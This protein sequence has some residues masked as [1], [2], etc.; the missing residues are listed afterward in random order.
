MSKNNTKEFLLKIKSHLEGDEAKKEA[1]VLQKDLTKI[2]SDVKASSGDT[3]QFKELE[4]FIRMLESHMDALVAEHGNDFKEIFSGLDAG[5]VKQMQELFQVTK[6]EL[7]AVDQ[8]RKKIANVQTSGATQDEANAI[9]AE[10]EALYATLGR[11]GEINI[12]DDLSPKQMVGESLRYLNNFIVVWDDVVEK[13]SRGFGFGG[14][15]LSKEIQEEVDK[16]TATK[17]QLQRTLDEVSGKKKTKVELPKGDE[18]QLDFL[19]KLVANYKEA[20][21]ARKSF[22]TRNDT[23][24]DGYKQAVAE[25]IAAAKR[26]KS[27]FDDDFNLGDDAMKYTVKHLEEYDDAEQAIAKFNKDKDVMLSQIESLYTQKM[28]GIEADIKNLM[29]GNASQQTKENEK[30]AISYDHLDQAIQKYAVL[31]QQVNDGMETNEYGE[32]IEGLIR[33]FDELFMSLSKTKEESKEVS[34]ILGDLSFGDIDT[35]QALEQLKPLLNIGE[36]SNFNTATAGFKTIAGEAERTKDA[37]GGLDDATTDTLKQDLEQI[38]KLAFQTNKELSF[39]VTADG[40]K[41]V[42]ESMEGMVKVSEEAAAAVHSVNSNMSILAHSHPGGKGLFSVADLYGG[43]NLKSSGA[44]SPIMALSK[45]VASVLN[46]DG[47]TDDVINKVRAKLDSLPKGQVMNQQI[48]TEIQDIFKD[49]GFEGA[50]QQ[51]NIKNGPD[52]LVSYLQ[53]ITVHAQE[54]QTPLEKLQGLISYYSNG[55]INAGN[56]SQFS[57][58]WAEFERGANTA[59]E[60]FDAVMAKIDARDKEGNLM[61]VGTADYQPLA[62]AM[63]NIA[64]GDNQ[65]AQG[66]FKSAQDA[67]NDF[68][69]IVEHVN[70]G[71]IADEFELGAVEQRLNDAKGALD[72]LHDQGLITFEQLEDATEDYERALSHL[73]EI[74]DEFIAANDKSWQQRE[75]LEIHNDLLKLQNQANSTDDVERLNQIIEKRNK[76]LEEAEKTNY[77]AG[78]ELDAERAITAEIEKRIDALRQTGDAVEE[79]NTALQQQKELYKYIEDA[80]KNNRKVSETALGK[81]DAEDFLGKTLD[82][83]KEKQKALK[84]YLKELIQI[85][86]QEKRNG[87][88]TEDEVNRR[89]ELIDLINDVRLGVRYKDG[90]NYDSGYFSEYSSSLYEDAEK[91]NEIVNLRKGIALGYYGTGTFGTMADTYNGNNIRDLLLE[92]AYKFDGDIQEFDKDMIGQ[93]VREYQ[94]LHQEM[95]ECLRV[96]DEVPQSTLDRLRWF[97]SLDTSKIEEVLPRLTEL[98]GKIDA[99]ESSG[100]ISLGHQIKQDDA[101]YDEKISNFQELI[102]LKKE[103]ANLGGPR[104]DDDYYTVDDLEHQLDRLVDAKNKSNDWR[105]LKT[106]FGNEHPDIDLENDQ[107][108]VDILDRFYNGWFKYDEALQK[109]NATYD[110]HNAAIEKA[111]AKL[112]EFDTV[113]NKVQNEKD[114]MELSEDELTNYR[115]ELE[116]LESELQQLSSQGVITAQDLERVGTSYKDI[117]KNI[118]NALEGKLRRQRSDEVPA[119]NVPDGDQVPDSNKSK[120]ADEINDLETLRLK[121]VEVQGAINAKTQAFVDEA[122]VVGTVVSKE[123]EALEVLGKYVDT[124]GANINSIIEGLSKIDNAKLNDSDVKTDSSTPSGSDSSYALDSTVKRTNEILGGIK[125]ALSGENDMSKLAESLK[126]AVDE[127]K[128][129]ASGIVDEQNRQKN[130]DKAIS[131]IDSPEKRAQLSDIVIQ[132]VS[133]DNLDNVRI[134]NNFRQNEDGTVDIGYALKNAE[135]VW[136]GYIAKVN[137]SNEV[138]KMSVN[139]HSLYAKELNEV[140][141]AS[142]KAADATE[143]ESNAKKSVKGPD[144]T[145]AQKKKYDVLTHAADPYVSD[146]SKVYSSKVDTAL[147]NYKNAFK[148]LKNAKEAVANADD[149]DIEDE[150]RKFNIASDACNRYAKELEDLIKQSS[151]FDSTHSNIIPVKRDTYNLDDLEESKQALIDYVNTTYEGKA[152][153]KEF[154]ES[155]K[156]LHF[157]M[158]DADGSIR[159]MH[160]A[161]D[162]T[163][164]AIGTAVGKIR[165]EGSLLSN[166]FNGLGKEATKLFRYFAARFGIE[167]VFQAFRTG[168]QYVRDI[169]RALTELKKVTSETDATYQNFLQTMSQVGSVI[170]ATTA[171]LVN[172]SADWARLGYSIQE[173]GELAKNTAILLNVSEFENVEEAT[174]AMVASLQAYGDQFDP[175]N[176]IEMIDKLNIVGNNF[177]VSSDGIAEALKRSASTLVESGNDFEQSIAMVAAAN[178]VIQDPEQVGAAL[179]VLSMRIRGTKTELEAMGESTDDMASTTSKLRDQVKALT[180]IDGSG[181]VDILTESGEYRDTYDILLDIA[182]VYDDILATDN[183]DAAALTELLAGKHRANVLSSLLQNADDLKEA[184]EMAQNAEGSAMAENERYLDSIQGR[185]DLFTNSLQT[186][187]MNFIDSEVIKGVVDAGTIL[188]KILDTLPGKIAAI[189]SGIMIY[190][191]ATDGIKF[192]E[193]FTGFINISGQVL[194]GIKSVATATTSLTGIT[195][196]QAIARTISDR[197]TKKQIISDAGLTAVNGKLTASQIKSTAA[198]LGEAR[199]NGVLTTSQYLAMMSTMGLKTALQGLWTVLKANPIYIVA[200]AATGL[201]LAFDAVFDTAQES[202]DEAQNAF[203]EVK[204]AVESTESTIQSLESE[205]TEIQNK[206]N[207]INGN[208]LSFAEDQELERLKAQKQELEHSLEVQKSILELQKKSQSEKAVDAMHAYTKAASQGAEETQ[209]S[210][211]NVLTTIGAIIGAGAA[212]A[213]AVPTGG[214]SL[215]AGGT[216]IGSSIAAAGLGG[217]TTGAIAGGIAGNKA[218]EWFGS[219]A[220][221]ND[222]G[223]DA[224]Y[225]TYTKALETA[226]AEKEKALKNYENDPS[227]I[228]KL[229]KWQEAE[230]KVTDIETEMYD[231]ISQLQQYYNS[232]DYDS[233]SNDVKAELNSWDQFLDKFNIDQGGA[234]AKATALDRIFGEN[235]SKEIKEIKAEIKEAVVTGKD[236]D[237]SA[238]INGSEDLRTALEY[239]GLEVQDVEDYFTQL[240]ESAFVD[241]NVTSFKGYSALVAQVES[242]NSALAQTSDYIFDNV[243]VTQEYKDS[244]TALGI[245]QDEL[246]DCF[247]ENNDLI[248]KNADALNELVDAARDNVSANIDVAE[249]HARLKYYDLVNQLNEVCSSTDEFTQSSSNLA[250]SLLDQIDAVQQ[251]IYKYHLLQN[252]LEGADGAFANF[253]EAKNIDSLNTTGATMIEMMQTLYDGFYKTGEVGTQA[254]EAAIDGLIPDSVLAGLESKGDQLEAAFKY[255][256]EELLPTLTKENDTISIGAGDVNSFIQEAINADVLARD[257]N[258]D[259]D[260]SKKALKKEWDFEDIGK[261]MGYSEAYVNAMMH[262]VDKNL[263]DDNISVK[264]SQGFEKFDNQILEITENIEDANRQKLDLLDQRRLTEDKD[265]IAAIDK[266]IGELNTTIQDNQK[267]MGNL[268]ETA[269]AE[270]E[271][272][273]KNEKAIAGLTELQDG[274]S[275]AEKLTATLTKDQ[276]KELGLKWKEGKTVQQYLDECLGKKDKLGEPTELTIQYALQGLAD[277]TDDLMNQIKKQLGEEEF[278]VK[279]KPYVEKNDDGTYSIDTT[280]ESSS[281]TRDE[282][283]NIVVKEGNY[284]EEELSTLQQIAENVNYTEDLQGISSSAVTAE[285]HLADISTNV[286][287]I[288]GKLGGNPVQSDTNKDGKVDTEKD[289]T[290]SQTN[291]DESGKSANNS[292]TDSKPMKMEDKPLIDV[293]KKSTEAQQKLAQAEEELAQINK[294]ALDP[295]PKSDDEPK[296]NY[297]KERTEKEQ[298]IRNL[299][300]QVDTEAIEKIENITEEDKEIAINAVTKYEQGGT[301][302]DLITDLQSIDPE[303]KTKVVATLVKEG[304]FDEL[305]SNLDESE[306]QIVIQAVTQGIGDAERLNEV[307]AGIENEEVRAEVGVLIGEALKNVDY[308]EGKLEATDG[309][310]INTTINGDSTGA[311]EAATIAEEKITGVTPTWTTA[312]LGDS[313]SAVVAAGTAQ[314]AI[315]GVDDTKETKIKATI[316]DSFWEKIRKAKEALAGVV[317]VNGTVHANGT[318]HAKGTAWAGGTA[319]KGGS[320]GAK[321]TETALVGELG[322]EIV[323]RGSR[324]FTVGDQGAEFANIQKGD[325]IFNHKQTEELFANGYITSRGKMKGTAHAQG[326]AYAGATWSI[327]TK[328]TNGKYKVKKTTKS[329]NNKKKNNKK[330]KEEF[331]EVFDWF[332]VRIEEINEDLDL[333]AAKLENAASLKSK[334]T[335]LDSMIKTNK[336]ELTTLEKGYQLYNSYANSILKK[337]K[338]VKNKKTGKYESQY[339]I[340]KKYWDEV[341][342][343]KIA[344]EEFYG[345]VDEKTL[346][347]IKNYREWAQKVADLKQQLQEVKTTIR[348]LAKQKIDNIADNWDNKIAVYDTHVQE[349]NQNYIDYTEESGKIAST[350]NYERMRTE[351]KHKKSHLTSK[352]DKMQE[353]FNKQVKNGNIQRGTDEWWEAV[354]AIQAINSEIDECNINLEKYQNAINQI[355][356]DTFDEVIKRFGYFEDEISSL[357]DMMSDAEMFKTTNENMEFWGEKDV[358]YTD[359]A[360]ASMGLYVEQMEIAK[361]KQQEYNEQIK[362]LKANKGNYSESEYKEKLAELTQGVYDSIEAQQEAKNALVDLEKA[363]VEYVKKGIEKQIEAYEELINKKKEELDA[364]KDLYDFQKGVEDQR[365]NISDIERKIAALAGDNSSAAVAERKR[366]E[367]ELAEAKAELE[368]TYYER[369]IDQQQQALDNELETFT[370]SKEAEIEALEKSTEEVDRIVSEATAE[371]NAR[372]DKIVELLTTIATANGVAVTQTVKSGVASTSKNAGK[373]IDDDVDK[374][375]KVVNKAANTAATDIVKKSSAVI[376]A[377]PKTT[378]TTTKTNT[379]T[380]N[381]KKTSTTNGKKTTT[382]NGKKTNTNS[383]KYYKEYTGKSGSIVDALKAI[384]VNSSYDNRAKIAKAN[385]IKNYSGTAKQNTKMLSLL[386]DGKLKKYA[387]GSLG[388]YRDQLAL[389]DELGEE[390]QLV[391]GNNGRLE[392]VKKGTGI[393]PADLTSNLMEWGKLDPQAMLEQN[394][395]AVGASPEVHATEVNL[396]IQYGDMLRIENFKGDNP[397]EIAKIV[398]KQFEKHTKDLNNALRKYVR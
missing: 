55:K 92:G 120:T 196:K 310:T 344:I 198:T 58:Y 177:A 105:K 256:K 271:K 359:E 300:I 32:D 12:A 180:N 75:G 273:A 155:V 369:S 197:A 98:K 364:E 176:S 360:L 184:Y 250:H 77:F 4:D 366:L 26:L 368:D 318:A 82:V 22:E 397:D 173:A 327:D 232:I 309:M 340:P 23:S 107:K 394:R 239:V 124:I 56:L 20:E 158:K 262:E 350:V 10:V 113:V 104:D 145:A 297:D 255:Y 252:S 153:I 343:G 163:G 352:R 186:F 168:V 331:Q 363:R 282:D 96:G 391:P 251:T 358:Q 109:M 223:Y 361:E 141:T 108:Y 349:R 286:A 112:Q 231:H 254:F 376:A 143:K 167:E 314:T 210:Y 87:E 101:Y 302:D 202:A 164:T 62:V 204:Q 31:Q 74:K 209:K 259:L 221:E 199:A 357:I 73:G 24:S 305:L 57:E 317:G 67:L 242:Y 35:A 29:S 354:Q 144:I 334:N 293:L 392:Y 61:Q 80:N 217:I 336:T 37:V 111:K 110:E 205:L 348:E 95:L 233:A 328:Q 383:T 41:Y 151:K 247:Y 178:K 347:Q 379:S 125:D 386:K 351:E 285:T 59:V 53:A 235:A 33:E 219:K 30:L 385:D 7:T 322:P 211:K 106:E 194:S 264:F 114:L 89:R 222:G 353:E 332:E 258:G 159:D 281:F 139:R 16:L 374:E 356:W 323:V 165:K 263:F 320:W 97:E 200:A 257:K 201:A 304:A 345:K 248:V 279:V 298:E 142:A 64:V 131:R 1:K 238:A 224:W 342:D 54:A 129:V 70:W 99:L 237:F 390:L 280:S 13:V 215:V 17:K 243:E 146:G 36:K 93:L 395:P 380:T 367:A 60:T 148:K 126:S 398:A 308:V 268:G 299:R 301:I 378:T 122:K 292:W 44:N 117:N 240:G 365:K 193:M 287:G 42:V 213:L 278:E 269:A 214:A 276:A 76:L 88:L 241:E 43:L 115:S 181:G 362:Y 288:L 127:L 265:Q 191:K 245:G 50:L 290:Q 94:F 212:I 140:A 135:G 325:I 382:T 192:T 66:P 14:P 324:W 246:A 38:H 48:F 341:K 216:A 375:T 121:L 333:M 330:A 370:E 5:F 244:L 206:I 103:Y 65:G 283:G 277:E 315:D 387:K 316:V 39:S 229:D 389:I 2:L 377:Q 169:D 156:Q 312:F 225:A 9:K 183:K 149:G 253:E 335:I 83:V 171:D 303:I 3:S 21:E 371:I 6:N 249:S 91:L 187:W 81:T 27:A 130:A 261:K 116:K 266:E 45:T 203:D 19:K 28:Q 11:S 270:Y 326:T 272:Y 78:Y 207:E 175:S 208:K 321:K 291:K 79:E 119:D 346:E 182:E 355:H 307:L 84:G 40:V 49:N 51:F 226:R 128:N 8:L 137:E 185:I 384:G 306:K 296:R 86:A 388:V 134:S 236:F 166:V 138:I 319:H 313:S 161:F 152:K 373:N 234:G 393:I 179:K 52:E 132:A 147:D 154:D 294:D 220:T 102:A 136:E 188:I 71:Q 190:K 339:I 260:I 174:E 18:E 274:L 100:D 123:T 72:E 195:L 157:T 34:R 396:N 372:G 162:A 381:G 228:A 170:G 90:S 227:N 160:A 311:V 284:S 118:S 275:D 337:T 85:G 172:S 267:K 218:G 230:Q 189:V 15:S 150:I 68:H 338:K 295:T 63:K 47:V 329:N 25:Q 133:P 69:D 289:K 46:L